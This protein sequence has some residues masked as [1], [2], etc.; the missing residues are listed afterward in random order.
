MCF[1]ETSVYNPMPTTYVPLGL[2]NVLSGKKNHR[3]VE[4]S[5][6]YMYIFILTCIFSYI[7]VNIY[8]CIYLNVLF[9]CVNIY[10]YIYTSLHVYMCLFMYIIVNTLKK[11]T[12]IIHGSVSYIIGISTFFT[13]VLLAGLNSLCR[14]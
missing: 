2:K 8:T 13:R 9:V 1:Q 14:G 4:E 10:I 12:S 5:E 3:Q 7:Y 11:Y 6:V